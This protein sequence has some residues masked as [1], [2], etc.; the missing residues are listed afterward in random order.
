[1][2]ALHGRWAWGDSWSG[3]AQLSRWAVS[4]HVEMNTSPKCVQTALSKRHPTRARFLFDAPRS[5]K[6]THAGSAGF[7]QSAHLSVPLIC[8]SPKIYV[9]CSSGDVFWSPGTKPV[10]CRVQPRFTK[11]GG[12]A[13]SCLWPML[14]SS[15]MTARTG[16]RRDEKENFLQIMS[17][18]GLA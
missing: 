8:L 10:S 6:S 4:F 16:T 17:E 3:C 14:P 15:A 11:M 5:T 18:Q 13:C 7:Q 1:M 2:E 9:V 12:A